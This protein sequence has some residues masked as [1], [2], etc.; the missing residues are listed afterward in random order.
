MDQLRFDWINTCF[1]LP[2]LVIADAGKQ[3][4]AKKF[5]Q[6]ITNIGI[7]VKNALIKTYYFIGMVKR[8]YRPLRQVYFIITTE[9]SGIEPDLVLQMFFIAINDSV[10]SNGLISTFL[11]FDVYSKI[12]EQDLLFPLITQH[13][14]AMQKAID[15]IQRF[16]AF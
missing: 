14:L 7:I 11:V 13:A 9:I 15:K 12:I 5:K 10:D 4:M 8:Y 3:F 2:D 6:Y 16:I 1:G